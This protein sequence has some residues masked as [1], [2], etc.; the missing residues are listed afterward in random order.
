MEL[1]LVGKERERGGKLEA[2]ADEAWE[3]KWLRSRCESLTST[4]GAER[5]KEAASLAQL[6]YPAWNFCRSSRGERANNLRPW[7]ILCRWRTVNSWRQQTIRRLLPRNF[8]S[9][10]TKAK[11]NKRVLNVYVS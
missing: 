8:G 9:K 5:R 4:S 2:S 11:D 1:D 6:V 7:A 3:D 10:L